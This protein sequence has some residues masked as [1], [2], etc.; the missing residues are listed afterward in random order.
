MSSTGS[1]VSSGLTPSEVVGYK[2]AGYISLSLYAVV[3]VGIATQLY[4]HITHHSDLKRIGFHLLLF[5]A[6]AAETP[7]SLQ[8]IVNPNS[9]QWIGMF[10]CEVYAQ[11]LQC[12]ALAMIALAWARAAA[13]GHH[14]G[15]VTLRKVVLACNVVIFLCVLGSSCVIATYPDT[16]AGQID[17]M[18]SPLYY[19]LV[20]SGCVTLLGTGFFLV[21][22]GCCIA[23]R[24]LRA[25][26]VLGEDE[27]YR[28][29][30]KLLVSLWTIMLCIC[31]R[32][33]FT[34]CLALDVAFIQHMDIVPFTVWST[35]VPDVFPA[36]CLLYLQRKTPTEMTHHRKQVR[37]ASQAPTEPYMMHTTEVS[38]V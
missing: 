35:L 23:T 8:F 6:V 18:K 33:F 17:F 30:S 29:L 9:T 3:T 34:A 19:V 14:D 27:V 12:F 37:V 2:V 36:L 22:Q 25:R 24:L 5:F 26:A 31:L 4:M 38:A 16:L 11:L 7:T 20:I 21:F 28:S 13:A 32:V 10:L 1:V 15:P